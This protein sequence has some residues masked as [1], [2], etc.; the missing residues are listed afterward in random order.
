MKRERE[1]SDPLRWLRV[2]GARSPPSRCGC[3]GVTAGFSSARTGKGFWGERRKLDSSPSQSNPSEEAAR[4]L[5]VPLRPP[6]T[7]L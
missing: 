2:Q 7:H 3:A 1:F 6:H 5:C 4:E